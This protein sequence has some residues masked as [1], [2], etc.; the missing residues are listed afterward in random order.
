MLS[1]L[2]PPATFENTFD[3]KTTRELNK[4][5]KVIFGDKY[6]LSIEQL[7]FKEDCFYDSQYHL[8]YECKESRTDIILDFILSL[9]F[10][11]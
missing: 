5:L 9:D 11:K 3:E 6:P 1:L 4:N 7:T 8:N 2:I 10:V